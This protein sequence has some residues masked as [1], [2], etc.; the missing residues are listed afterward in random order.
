V[1]IVVRHAKPEATPEVPPNEWVLSDSGV[2]AASALRLRLPADGYLVSSGEPKAWQTLGGSDA[3]R[4]D[5]R[6]NEVERIAEPWGD[7]F[8]EK[9]RE[10]VSGTEHPGWESHRSVARRFQAAVDDHLGS[11]RGDPLV[12]ASHGM[13][14]TIWL[15]SAGVIGPDR[16]AAFWLDLRFPDCHGVDLT[17]RS[18]RRL[19]PE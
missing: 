10:Y 17:A 14:I 3:V 9:R 11:C 6:F 5:R 1:L 15:V 2:A 19:T 12:V 7:D 16:A 8:R 13:A 4:K 18:V